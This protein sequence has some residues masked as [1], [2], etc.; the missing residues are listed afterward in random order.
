MGRFQLANV[1]FFMDFD[2]FADPMSRFYFVSMCYVVGSGLCS[3]FEQRGPL[4]FY[5]GCFMVFTIII[6][7]KTVIYMENLESSESTLCFR[8]SGMPSAVLFSLCCVLLLH[9]LFLRL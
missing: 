2:C 5:H 1:V 6:L 4:L 7:K 8:S 9:N 3:F